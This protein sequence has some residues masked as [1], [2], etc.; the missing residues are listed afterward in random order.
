[1]VAQDATSADVLVAVQ[2]FTTDQKG[3]TAKLVRDRLTITQ[4]AQGWKISAVTVVEPG[5]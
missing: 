1:M 2:V 4:T 3:S 5:G